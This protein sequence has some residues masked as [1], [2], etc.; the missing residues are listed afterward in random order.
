LTSKPGPR[1]DPTRLPAEVH[2][3]A[4]LIQPQGAFYDPS[5]NRLFVSS[6][7]DGAVKIFDGSTFEL[8]QTVKFSA[9]ADIVRY[10]ARGKPVIVGYGGRSQIQ[11]ALSDKR[12]RISEKTR[13]LLQRLLGGYFVGIEITQPLSCSE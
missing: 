4:N 1:L 6:S 10:D 11:S 5:T 2:T 3:I 7:G 9:D 13:Q 8:L 12:E